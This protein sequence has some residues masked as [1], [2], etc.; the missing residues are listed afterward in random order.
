MSK[1]KSKKVERSEQDLTK[2]VPKIKNL[3]HLKYLLNEMQDAAL[4]NMSLDINDDG[5]F[6]VI[7]NVKDINMYLGE[8]GKMI[9]RNPNFVELDRYFSNDVHNLIAKA[10][11]VTEEAKVED[12]ID[13][14]FEEFNREIRENVESVE[15][16]GKAYSR[17]SD[18]DGFIEARRK[19]MTKEFVKG[20]GS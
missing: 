5:R 2:T 8:L 3:K 11:R 19:D 6:D 12:A 15:V 10:V 20:V 9:K 13:E 17:T 18:I 7:Y 4:K 14:F 1:N 16:D